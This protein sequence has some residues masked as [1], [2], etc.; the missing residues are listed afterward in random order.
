MGE[1]G[2][3][4]V[5]ISGP[6]AKSMYDKTWTPWFDFQSDKDGARVKVRFIKQVNMNLI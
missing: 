5:D 3:I 2:D 1:A 4:P 6:S